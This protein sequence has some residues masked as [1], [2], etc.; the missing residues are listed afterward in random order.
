MHSVRLRAL[1][2]VVGAAATALGVISMTTLPAWPV[3]GVAVAA[4]ALVLN[5]ITR[6]VTRTTCLGCGLGLDKAPEGSHGRM[7][8]HCGA[9][10]ERLVGDFPGEHEA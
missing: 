4:V 10:N 7:C 5:T 3:L 6:G 2:V 1:W 8:P 9:V